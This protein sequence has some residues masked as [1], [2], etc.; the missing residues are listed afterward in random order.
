MFAQI[1][2][3]NTKLGIRVARDFNFY[4]NHME[5]TGGKRVI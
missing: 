3:I 1:Y 4:D 5:P 2:R